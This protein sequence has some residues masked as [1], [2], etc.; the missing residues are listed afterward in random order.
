MDTYKITFFRHMTGERGTMN[1]KNEKTT[2]LTKDEAIELITKCR[3]IWGLFT[4]F[5]IEKE[6]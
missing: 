4:T 5:N 2:G 6:V 1:I 3:R